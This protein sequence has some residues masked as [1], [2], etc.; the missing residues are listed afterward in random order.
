[1]DDVQDEAHFL[2]QKIALL[3]RVI[4]ELIKDNPNGRTALDAA[5][6]RAQRD[7]EE[8]ESLSIDRA[9]EELG[10]IAAELKRLNR[11]R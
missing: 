8:G 3:A 1:M 10:R 9:S 2:R 4:T 7:L 6:A 11:D 5:F